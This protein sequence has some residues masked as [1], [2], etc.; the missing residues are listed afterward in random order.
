MTVHIID[1]NNYVRRAF[2]RGETI[3]Q[4]VAQNPAELYIWVFD[5]IGAKRPRTLLY[6]NYKAKRNVQAAIDNGFYN[7]LR[8]VE[9]EF[10]PY[11]GNTLIIKKDGLEADDIIAALVNTYK[12]TH[13][14]LIHSNDAD[15]QTLVSDTV[16]VTD[17]SKTLAHVEPKDVRLYKTLVGDSSDNIGGIEGFGK[18]KWVQLSEQDKENWE[19]WLSGGFDDTPD[20]MGDMF[21]HAGLTKK[22]LGW[23][24][25]TEN[26]QLLK[27]YWQ[28]VG[29]L[30]VNMAELGDK[31]TLV[32]TYNS[33]KLQETLNKFMWD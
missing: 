4:M 23:M 32:G 18:G 1:A 28:I 31:C 7:F 13:P 26:Q 5:G 14:I 21:P 30:P 3:T 20:W 15:F 19:T 9:R 11:C 17:K 10:L 24:K 12:S 8:T 33:F 29:F 2:E 25:V 16:K 6:P 27:V 22:P